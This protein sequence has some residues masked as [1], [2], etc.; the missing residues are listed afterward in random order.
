MFYD[1]ILQDAA[2]ANRILDA[3]MVRFSHVSAASLLHPLHTSLMQFSRIQ[4]LW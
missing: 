3:V 1:R 4:M 2:D